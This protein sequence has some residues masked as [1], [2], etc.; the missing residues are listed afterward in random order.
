M[1]WKPGDYVGLMDKQ[2]VH[3]ECS[4]QLE[5][6]ATAL[7]TNVR[8]KVIEGSQPD[9]WAVITRAEPFIEAQESEDD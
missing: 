1:A 7:F 3:F 4:P 2:I 8:V 6:K 9:F 5:A